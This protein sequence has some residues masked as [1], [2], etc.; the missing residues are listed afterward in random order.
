MKK[1]YLIII[2]VILGILVGGY[3][4]YD[5][6]F[7]YAEPIEYPNIEENNFNKISIV[8]NKANTEFEIP[9]DDILVYLK[10]A[11]PTRSISV[12]E[13][14]GTTPYYCVEVETK[15]RL[16]I[17]YI[18]EKKS[19]VYVEVPYYGVYIIDEAVLDLFA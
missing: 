13:S 3:L 2:V 1:R 4:M 8:D 16:Y 19:K 5:T 6:M 14:P 10:K 17:Y 12:S 18:Y 7:P 15:E 11:K 9:F